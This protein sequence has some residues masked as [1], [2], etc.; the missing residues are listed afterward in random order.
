MRVS[1]L[2]KTSGVYLVRG[3]FCSHE[4]EEIEV[5]NTST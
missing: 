2:P 1:N 4:I 5:Y 3:I